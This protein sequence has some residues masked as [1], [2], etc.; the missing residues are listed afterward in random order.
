MTD[1]LA[2]WL[3]AATMVKWPALADGRIL[4]DVPAAE[5]FTGPWTSIDRPWNGDGVLILGEHGRGHSVWL[6]WD[7]GRFVGW[8]VNLEAPWRPFA[9][10]FDT[11]DYELDVW[12]ASDGSWHWK[13]EE[14][15]EAAVE[16]GYF[17][18]AQ[19]AAVRAEGERVIAEWPFPTGWED[20]RPD[21]GWPLPSVPGDW[22]VG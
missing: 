3:P 14:D 22:D 4:R 20:W 16:A 10:G 5:R 18:P 13:D 7:A 17:T 1:G 15:L 2:L 8:Y 19:A 21:P 12:V 6:F 9:A 11:E